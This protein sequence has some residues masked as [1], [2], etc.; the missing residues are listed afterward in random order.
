MRVV[1]PS[2]LFLLSLSLATIAGAQPVATALRVGV[3]GTRLGLTRDWGGAVP[4]ATLDLRLSR[5]QGPNWGVVLAA[6][7]LLPTE[8]RQATSIAI[9]DALEAS[10]RPVSNHAPDVGDFSTPERMMGASLLLYRD[11]ARGTL[12]LT[13][14]L[15][16]LRAVGIEGSPASTTLYEG[17]L[18]YRPGRA[19]RVQP[20]VGLRAMRGVRAV[21]GIRT[22][23]LPS[24][25]ATFDW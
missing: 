7:Y 3:G 16:T 24:V 23:V 5:A 12:R 11:L 4:A 2:A 15:G 18:E 8:S 9:P 1:R 22:I 17:G 13:A 10:A 14:G 19:R 20:V 25:G 6:Q 21:G